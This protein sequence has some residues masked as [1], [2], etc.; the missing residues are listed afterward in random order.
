MSGAPKCK[1]VYGPA[2]ELVK[3]GATAHV[4]AYNKVVPVVKK[5]FTRDTCGRFTGH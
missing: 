2:A 3:N 5:E 1:K 4:S